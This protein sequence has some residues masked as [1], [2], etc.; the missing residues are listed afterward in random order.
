MPKSIECRGKNG[1][2]LSLF[3]QEHGTFSLV[4]T[5]VEKVFGE[6]LYQ[7]D[8][9]IISKNLNCELIQS[10]I[11]CVSAEE[12]VVDIPK[13]GV[14]N[15]KVI[16]ESRFTIG[17]FWENG[18]R[19]DGQKSSRYLGLRAQF[20]ISFQVG[21]T[22]DPIIVAGVNLNTGEKLNFELNKTLISLQLNDGTAGCEA[23]D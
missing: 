13:A 9:V 11:Y 17:S 16:R 20:E 15:K 8:S 5:G 2:N 4:Y 12:Q 7:L 3:T 10:Q 22:L 1:S 23:K 18:V 19:F 6:G 21:E 14:S